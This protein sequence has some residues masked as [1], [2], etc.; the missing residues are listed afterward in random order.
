MTNE[1]VPITESPDED[2]Y[3]HY[4]RSEDVSGSIYS[5]IAYSDQ[6]PLD[7]GI[8]GIEPWKG[9]VRASITN[10]GEETDMSL[11][12]EL[13]PED[14]RRAARSLILSAE[15]AEKHLAEEGEQ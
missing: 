2:K 7:W 13:S 3:P 5:T 14:A 6:V 8:V 11:G 15:W 12:V 10:E 9:V 4:Y 1:N